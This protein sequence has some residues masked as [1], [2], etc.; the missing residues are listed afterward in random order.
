MPV[1]EAV[2]G[3]ALTNKG[4]RHSGTVDTHKDAL[5]GQCPSIMGAFVQS[6]FTCSPTL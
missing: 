6:S 1:L 3:P 4:S 5:L 2:A